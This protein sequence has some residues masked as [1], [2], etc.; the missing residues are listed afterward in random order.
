MPDHFQLSDHCL[1]DHREA[2]GT[3]YVELPFTAQ[4]VSWRIMLHMD[5]KAH[6]VGLRGWIWRLLGIDRS[7][8]NPN[9]CNA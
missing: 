3:G 9:L 5:R 1:V 4:T 7:L 2:L 6:F 8:K